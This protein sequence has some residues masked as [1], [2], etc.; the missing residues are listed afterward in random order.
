[1]YCLHYVDNRL[2]TDMA[3]CLEAA[4]FVQGIGAGK[5]AS[6]PKYH[7]QFHAFLKGQIFRYLLISVS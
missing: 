7:R 1:M 6:A 2:G 5:V 3:F 4:L